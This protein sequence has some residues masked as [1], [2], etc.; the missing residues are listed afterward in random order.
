[1]RQITAQI[2]WCQH[3]DDDQGLPFGV[4][5]KPATH[6]CTAGLTVLDD[7]ELVAVFA[8]APGPFDDLRDVWGELLERL[9][10]VPQQQHLTGHGPE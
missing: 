2:V 1:M 3:G 4:G 7:D 6:P 10:Q 9:H 5:G 8:W